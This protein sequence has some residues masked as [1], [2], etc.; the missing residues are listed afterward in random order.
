MPFKFTNNLCDNVSA[1]VAIQIASTIMAII[2]WVFIAQEASSHE[3]LFLGLPIALIIFLAGMFAKTK[4]EVADAIA[5]IIVIFSI[6][7]D[8]TAG[9]TCFTATLSILF[10]IALFCR[11]YLKGEGYNIIISILMLA[12]GLCVNFA[13][14]FDGNSLMPWIVLSVVGISIIAS[15]SLFEKKPQLFAKRKISDNVNPSEVVSEESEKGELQEIP[16][17]EQ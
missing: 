14:A 2:G 11:S 12:L 16:E 5:Y 7:A 17:S 10:A 15:A 3:L 13:L 1:A 8:F 9:A 4:I 6:I